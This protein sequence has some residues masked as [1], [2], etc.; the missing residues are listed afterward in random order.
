MGAGFS[1]KVSKKKYEEKIDRKD[2]FNI[3]KYVAGFPNLLFRDEIWSY[4][5]FKVMKCIHWKHGKFVVWK[6][7][8]HREQLE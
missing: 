1:S 3:K 6:I 5:L 8:L 7:F 4:K 2:E